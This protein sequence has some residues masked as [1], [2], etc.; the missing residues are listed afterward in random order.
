MTRAFVVGRT[1]RGRPIEP[2]VRAV[3]DSLRASGW[4]VDSKVVRRKSA[5]THRAARAVSAGCDVV[6]V[7]PQDKAW[8]NDPF[9]SSPDY[10]LAENRQ[11]RWRI[12]LRV[13]ARQ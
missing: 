7:V 9:A 6:V 2:T 12:Y 10:S 11:G 1:R 8:D 4:R 13:A 5:M 3:R